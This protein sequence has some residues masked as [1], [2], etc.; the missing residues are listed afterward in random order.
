MARKKTKK[1]APLRWQES[2]DPKDTITALNEMEENLRRLG[3]RNEASSTMSDA[4]RAGETGSYVMSIRKAKEEAVKLRHEKE[5][6]Q[7]AAEEQKRKNEMM[8]SYANRE[9]VLQEVIKKAQGLL[10]QE[11]SSTHDAVSGRAHKLTEKAIRAE[12]LQRQRVLRDRLH[13][14]AK[15]SDGGSFP[16]QQT[17]PDA[18]DKM[19]AM[20][21]QAKAAATREYC[22]NIAS[23]L[24][25]L[26][27]QVAE[28][29][30]AVRAENGV[31]VLRVPRELPKSQW[32]AW[33]NEFVFAKTVS[34][35][36]SDVLAVT[37][38]RELCDPDY[39]KS[40]AQKEES[41]GSPHRGNEP[42]G[43]TALELARDLT[44]DEDG[45]SVATDAVAENILTRLVVLQQSYATNLVTR[46]VDSAIELIK[47]HEKRR[48]RAELD[49]LRRQH[50]PQCPEEVAPG[51]THRLPPA[52]CFLHG[53]ELSG[54]KKFVDVAC[55]EAAHEPPQALPS[56][57]RRGSITMAA[58][59]ARAMMESEGGKWENEQYR[60]LTPAMLIRTQQFWGQ[61]GS[62]GAGG[63]FATCST[64]TPRGMGFASSN[65]ARAREGRSP[66]ELTESN[67]HIDALCD[68]LAKE[69][70]AVYQYNLQ[71][72]IHSGAAVNEPK[73]PSKGTPRTL[74]LVGFP[75]TEAFLRTLHQ[76]L[77]VAV[78]MVEQE[79]N[80][81]LRAEETTE[82]LVHQPPA[83]GRAS[84]K[85]PP[86]SQDI[87][88]GSHRKGTRL[89]QPTTGKRGAGR[90]PAT[91]NE[92]NFAPIRSRVYPPL[93]LLGI[94]LLYDVPSRLRRMQ[95][96]DARST[97]FTSELR[98]QR[99]VAIEEESGE[100]YSDWSIE[101]LHQELIQQ[102]R[103]MRKLWKTWCS[104]INRTSVS[105]DTETV[106]SPYADKQKRRLRPSIPGKASEAVSPHPTPVTPILSNTFPKVLFFWRKEDLTSLSESNT[107]AEAITAAIRVVLNPTVQS[108]T[109]N[110]RLV[111]GQLAAPLN[112]G[113]YRFL[114]AALAQLVDLQQRFKTR[115]KRQ[116]DLYAQNLTS[117]LA[118]SSAS[119]SLQSTRTVS[120]PLSSAP[121][122]IALPAN[123]VCML[124]AENTIYSRERDVEVENMVLL[125]TEMHRTFCNFFLDLLQFITQDAFPPSLWGT[126]Q[127]PSNTTDPNASAGVESF[128]RTLHF[129]SIDANYDTSRGALQTLLV[130]GMTKLTAV[131]ALLLHCVLGLALESIG[132]ALARLC[133]WARCQ[134]CSASISFSDAEKTS[135]FFPPTTTPTAANNLNNTVKE[136]V[137]GA[138]QGEEAGAGEEGGA[139]TLKCSM[140]TDA[141]R[142][143]FFSSVTRLSFEKVQEMVGLLDGQTTS[144]KEFQQELWSYASHVQQTMLRCFQAF[145][146]SAE[147]ELSDGNAENLLAMASQVTEVL[148]AHL[149]AFSPLEQRCSSSTDE[150][151][152]SEVCSSTI[153]V[154]I[155]RAMASIRA[156]RRCCAVASI[157]A[158]RWIDAMYVTA[159]AVPPHGSFPAERRPR[160]IASIFCL[161]NVG[162]R[163]GS[164]PP[165]SLARQLLA[166]CSPTLALSPEEERDC[167]WET[168]MEVTLQFF[169]IYQKP[170]L[171]KVEFLHCAMLVQLS[172]LWKLLPPKAHAIA[173]RLGVSLPFTPRAAYKNEEEKWAK[174]EFTLPWL[175]GVQCYGALA[176]PFV[177][178]DDARRIF[179]A[180]VQAQQQ[181]FSKCE[182]SYDPPFS[183]SPVSSSAGVEMQRWTKKPLLR[184][185][186]YFI[187][188]ILRRLCLSDGD[189]ADATTSPSH[190]GG[191]REPSTMQLRRM[192]KS[193]PRVVRE[194][195]PDSMPDLCPVSMEEWQRIMWWPFFE[196][197]SLAKAATF[198]KRYLL[199]LL[200]VCFGFVNGEL[201]SR[202]T[203]FL[204]D[205]LYLAAG[206]RGCQATLERYFHAIFA[207]NTARERKLY[208]SQEAANT[209]DTSDVRGGGDAVVL[210]GPLMAFDFALTVEEAMFFFQRA[211]ET[212]LLGPC[213]R[214]MSYRSSNH[215]CELRNLAPEAEADEVVERA[216]GNSNGDNDDDDDGEQLPLATELTLLLEVE[217]APALTLTLLGSSHWGNYITPRL[218]AVPLKPIETMAAAKSKKEQRT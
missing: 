19:R 100:S 183:I 143:S 200:T 74:F 15:G 149:F 33:V 73:F 85:G 121:P 128:S 45:N 97:P 112:L 76:K 21:N 59:T 215:L 41:V 156:L 166:S 198:V 126:L 164:A 98:G 37:P 178:E 194:Q 2:E 199:R 44:P 167:W 169:S 177:T 125:E 61:G 142:R 52:G 3:L 158:A 31:P 120:P 67:P 146:Q 80:R 210:S 208:H 10:R 163:K 68:A 38:L 79:I 203:P 188:V 151:S 92:D 28:N 214:G 139:A 136:E 207:L 26:A 116:T 23:G 189:G 181:L 147:K 187:S 140:S 65:A 114:P 172:S 152:A 138:V 105:L 165:P 191:W 145:V 216:M 4:L 171:S 168:E 30:Y 148:V 141:V 13:Q 209:E 72:V 205:V 115:W 217:G 103:K 122:P 117:T 32:R 25:E 193:L 86:T 127:Q 174:V 119:H 84:H 53:D 69:L 160:D 113:D 176:K 111:R 184:V 144:F 51:W 35:P 71:L 180:A 40:T 218:T 36:I 104:G 63:N 5:Y 1:T 129:L 42:S 175:G 155:G 132:D 201:C 48:L 34:K 62:V 137:E 131:C 70:A 196:D 130:D 66:E 204:P 27:M 192:I 11:M 81:A 22:H 75:E 17:V 60:V 182:S 157:C 55:G 29:V 94:F 211:G 106:Q 88:A 101:K 153:T 64:K 110:D 123:T 150:A 6:R 161:P 90:L 83:K 18:C 82:A 159:L 93:C 43:R 77:H 14:S 179:F 57:R 46:S 58:E 87:A 39:K 109:R 170:V 133:F 190:A 78:E 213:A 202:C 7:F 95:H 99:T 124:P 102:D 96:M 24:L 134:M 16:L 206:T 89:I 56:H 91:W 49:R 185:R 135:V 50:E 20:K 173:E 12:E 9:E 54:L 162:S 108:V 186:E 8:L 195:G 107:A 47:K 154:S 212:R 197:A 118:L